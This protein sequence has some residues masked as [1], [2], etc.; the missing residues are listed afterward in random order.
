MVLATPYQYLFNSDQGITEG[1]FEADLMSR[2]HKV[3][4]FLE[5]VDYEYQDR[6]PAW[7]LIAYIENH[8]SGAIEAWQTKYILGTDGARST[9]RRMTGVTT[10]SQG[11]EDVWAVADVFL[12]TDFP[13]CRR[14][15][16]IR[17]PYGGCMLI[18]R[19]DEG[20]RVFLQLTQEDLQ[21]LDESKKQSATKGLQNNEA[22][23]LLDIVQSQ[24][25]KVLRPYK[26]E[27]T[28]VLWISRYTV[29]QRI[30]NRFRDQRG[31]VFLL[32][33]ACHTHSPKAGQGMNVSISDAYNLTWK[34]AI[35]MKGLANAKLLDTY[36]IER[37]HIATEL[38]NFD[39]KFAKAFTQTTNLGDT[40][41]HDL[42]QESHGFTSGC[43]YRYPQGLLVSDQ[44]RAFVNPKA[45]EPVIPGK[46]L[47]SI[48][49]IRQLD[50][51]S[52]QLLDEMPADGRFH[53]FVC[54][55]KSLVSDVFV[56]LSKFLSSTTSPLYRFNKKNPCLLGPFHQEDITSTYPKANSDYVVDVFLLHTTPHLEV[57][58]ELLPQP[59]SDKW[60]ARV[61]AGL[62]SIPKAS[63]L[64][65]YTS[66]LVSVSVSANSIDTLVHTSYQRKYFRPPLYPTSF[67]LF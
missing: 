66:V 65:R 54:A 44:M 46:R 39:A 9:I 60:S 57:G 47:L 22:F 42:W 43:G 5:I 34:L 64:Y 19:K 21:V 1:I 38:I 8:I 11:G 62:A 10:Q 52:V 49:L 30:V 13:D 2:G 55:G 20:L 35:V 58:L 4:R 15:V 59:F 16:A 53:L 41:L 28:K 40:T 37:K 12:N 17:S 29:S 48:P 23:K 51:N 6:D 27:I 56:Q 67:F 18:P 36:E 50:G 32:G 31:S 26:F 3:D 45:T 14:R 33:D 7:P 61:Y 24:A 25:Q 63:I